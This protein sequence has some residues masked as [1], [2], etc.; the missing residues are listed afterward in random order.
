MS[1]GRASGIRRYVPIL[2]WLPGYRQRGTFS[3]DV[4]AGI[5]VAALLIPESMGYAEI[6]GLPFAQARF[7]EPVS[8]RSKIAGGP[9][10]DQFEHLSDG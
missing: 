3:A 7:T 6:A 2:S 8:E 5:S 9:G 10:L 1:D 4:V